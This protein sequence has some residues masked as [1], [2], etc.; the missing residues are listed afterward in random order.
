MCFLHPQQEQ[1]ANHDLLLETPAN[2]KTSKMT[3][4]QGTHIG[5]TPGVDALL[6][7]QDQ[8]DPAFARKHDIWYSVT[9]PPG[10][11]LQMGCG[12]F[13]LQEILPCIWTKKPDVFCPVC[14]TNLFAQHNAAMTN[15]YPL[16]DE[17]YCGTVF[18]RASP[19]PRPIEYQQSAVSS[20]VYARVWRTMPSNYMMNDLGSEKFGNLSQRSG[21]DV[22]TPNAAVSPSRTTRFPDSVSAWGEEMQGLEA[23][24]PPLYIEYETSQ[25]HLC[26]ELLQ[27]MDIEGILSGRR[28]SFTAEEL[29]DMEAYIEEGQR[30]QE[31]Q[32]IEDAEK[33]ANLL[34]YM[35]DLERKHPI[36]SSIFEDNGLPPPPVDQIVARFMAWKGSSGRG[37]S[38]SGSTTVESW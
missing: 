38:S 25:Q 17:Y 2:I 12:T 21:Q 14:P 18:P 29:A 13:G 28:M 24:R 1:R 6:P 15:M 3:C 23:K 20:E 8:L 19:Q 30:E 26:Q 35:A 22:W 31:L 34:Y 7:A 27:T 37:S 36:E 16:S 10:I 11:F 33:E 4:V 9:G 5:L 32:E